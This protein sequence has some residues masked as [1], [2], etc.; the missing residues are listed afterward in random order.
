MEIIFSLSCRLINSSM[1]YLF[2]LLISITVINAELPAQQEIP[3]QTAVEAVFGVSENLDL[4]LCCFAAYGWHVTSEIK[5]EHPIVGMIETQD[6]ASYLL[7][8][9]ITPM[10]EEQYFQLADG[11]FVVIVSE[12][13]YAKVYGRFLINLNAK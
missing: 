8:N 11:R 12:A 9:S 7:T 4:N 2:T 6:I 13:T 3:G 10:Q 5:G 1:K